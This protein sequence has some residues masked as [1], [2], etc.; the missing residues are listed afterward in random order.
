MAMSGIP[1]QEV[2]DPRV[3]VRQAEGRVQLLRPLEVAQRDVRAAGRAV[4]PDRPPVEE[5]HERVEVD[6]DGDLAQRLVEAPP[7]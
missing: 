1:L 7:C 6:G 4:Q 3:E 5:R 2:R